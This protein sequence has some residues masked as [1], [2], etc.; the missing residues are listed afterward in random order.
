MN[1]R[2]VTVACVRIQYLWPA[3][4]AVGVAVSGCSSS[5]TAA[6]AKPAANAAVTT[7]KAKAAGGCVEILKLA[8]SLSKSV[9]GISSGTTTPDQF[10]S[11][12]A[13][14]GTKFQAAADAT[15]DPEVKAA[16]T[17][18]AAYL[19][20]MSKASDSDLTKDESSFQTAAA[21]LDAKCPN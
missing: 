12:A 6:P 10:R 15:P 18:F 2:Y 13:D 16:T 14:Y 7:T 4:L 3:L 8:D 5:N 17:K 9:D 21:E 1:G 20:N 19:T 11:V